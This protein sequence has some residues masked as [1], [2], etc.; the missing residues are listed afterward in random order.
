MNLIKTTLL[1]TALSL[2]LVAAGGMLGGAQG[3][4]IA[5]VLAL[6]MNLATYWFSDKLVLRMYRAREASAADTPELYGLVRQLA[7]EVAELGQSANAQGWAAA[8][9]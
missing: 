9:E 5:L 2:L 1:L 7:G 4:T 6:G 8:A 3:M